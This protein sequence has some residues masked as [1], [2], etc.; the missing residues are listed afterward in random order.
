MVKTKKKF[1]FIKKNKIKTQQSLEYLYVLYTYKPSGRVAYFSSSFLMRPKRPQLPIRRRNVNKTMRAS[2]THKLMTR[3]SGIPSYSLIMKPVLFW[4]QSLQ[5]FSMSMIEVV[6]VWREVLLSV[7]N[8][9]VSDS[10]VVV[11][12]VDYFPI[13]FHQFVWLKII[14][15]LRL[16][17]CIY[18]YLRFLVANKIFN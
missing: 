1:F 10:C 13:C 16:S 3:F 8:A 6:L 18:F 7:D 11:D 2:H 14:F 4:Q 17:F 12:I 9:I 5:L 15:I